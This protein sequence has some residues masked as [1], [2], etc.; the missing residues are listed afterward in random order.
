M[1]KQI[2]IALTGLALSASTVIGQAAI[3]GTVID[4]ACYKAKMTRADA[5]KHSR[6]CAL[7]PD[8]SKSGFTVVAENGQAYKLD[9]KGNTDLVAAL[10]ASKKANDLRVTVNGTVKGDTIAVTSITLDK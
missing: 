1:K 9:A 10:N 3:T 7:M 4:N 2:L 6:D 5:G 8:C